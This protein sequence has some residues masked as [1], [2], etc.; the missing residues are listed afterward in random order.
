MVIQVVENMEPFL[1]TASL[2]DI[3]C[4]AEH[5]RKMF[6]EIGEKKKIASDP[7]LLT[8]LEHEYARKL[9]EELKSGA[10]IAW[11]TILEDRIVSSGAISI[12]SYVPVPHDLS[13]KIAFLHSIYTE[14]EYRNNGY[15]QGITCEAAQNCKQ[16]GISRLYLFSSDDGRIIYEKNGFKPVDNVMMLFQP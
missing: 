16:R 6:E 5:H 7:A 4:L 13:S 8:I 1:R 11:V 12:L 14:K 3:P 10:C 2:E 15:A 9:T